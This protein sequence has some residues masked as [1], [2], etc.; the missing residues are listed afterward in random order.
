MASLTLIDDFALTNKYL[1][2]HV[3]LS[4]KY[5]KYLELLNHLLAF[6]FLVWLILIFKNLVLYYNSEKPFIILVVL[7]CTL[8]KIIISF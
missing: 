2:A 3:I 4:F 6:S 5:L 7:F 1:L 8:S